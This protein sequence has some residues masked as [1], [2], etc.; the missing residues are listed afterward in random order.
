MSRRRKSRTPVTSTTAPDDG[1]P[2]GHLS[3]AEL[4]KELARRRLSRGKIDLD[5]IESFAEDAQRDM[6]PGDPGS[7][8]RL[9]AA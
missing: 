6:R 4:M 9:V 8:D 3:D 5:A 7:G 2:L 1:S